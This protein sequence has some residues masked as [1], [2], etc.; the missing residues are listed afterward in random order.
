MGAAIWIE[1]AASN[2][3]IKN[4]IVFNNTTKSNYYALLVTDDAGIAITSDYNLFYDSLATSNLISYRNTTY[5]NS[6]WSAYKSAKSQD[7]HSLTPINPLFVSLSDFSPQSSSPVRNSG[8][9]VGLPFTG[10]PTIGAFEYV[11]VPVIAPV[12]ATIQ[13]YGNYKI[14]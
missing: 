1:G 10:S 13:L 7:A 14:N 8:V 3:T 11:I 4:N 5:T 12:G 6:G 9:N 2:A